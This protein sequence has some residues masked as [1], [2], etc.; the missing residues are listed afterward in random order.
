MTNLVFVTGNTNKV[1]WVEKFLGQK[2]EHHKLD[3]DEIQDLDPARV[4]EHKAREAY[5]ILQKPVLVEDSSLVFNALGRLPGTFIKFFN[6]EIGNEKMCRLLDS[7]KDRSATNQVIFGLY[8]GKKFFAFEAEV[9]GRIAN[10][11]RGNLG[12]GF[13]SIFIPDGQDKTRAEMSEEVYAKYQPRN[14]AVLKLAKHLQKSQAI[15]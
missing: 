6:E 3:L 2:L 11:P 15:V 7:F 14:K 5:K 4:L 9:K 10:T 12:F 8:D 1:Y 13:D